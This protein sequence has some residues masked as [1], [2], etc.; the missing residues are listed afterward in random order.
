[1]KTPALTVLLVEDDQVDVMNIQRI[2]RKAN[3]AHS[4]L[5][6][7]NGCEALALLQNA[8]TN[9]PP[10]RR[11]ILLDLNMPK[12]GG[13][14]FLRVL[15]QD[16]ILKDTPVIVLTTSDQEEDRLAAEQS[17]VLG[18]IVKPVTFP[19]LTEALIT[20]QP[21]QPLIRDFLIHSSRLTPL[22]NG[23]DAGDFTGR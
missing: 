5:V 1:M 9:L 13:L 10:A 15:R 17:N 3:F 8:K 14:E 23:R 16:P 20:L 6:V 11:L 22:S 7:G 4:L 18:Y 2:F 12:M 19:K 21:D